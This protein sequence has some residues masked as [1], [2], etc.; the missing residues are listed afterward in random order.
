MITGKRRASWSKHLPLALS[1]CRKA[2][3]WFW[4]PQ[5]KGEVTVNK[6]MKTK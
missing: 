2:F 6:L 5:Q 1:F 3:T 4:V